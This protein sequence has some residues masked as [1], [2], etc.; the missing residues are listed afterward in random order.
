MY[1]SYIINLPP[2]LGVCFELEQFSILRCKNKYQ[3][4]LFSLVLYGY[5]YGQCVGT[6][7][8]ICGQ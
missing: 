5:I 2:T 8:T 3:A 6:A 4:C 7:G 1:Y